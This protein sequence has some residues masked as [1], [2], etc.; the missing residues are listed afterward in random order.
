MYT[1]NQLAAFTLLETKDISDAIE[2]IIMYTKALENA[3]T[4]RLAKNYSDAML[5]DSSTS[6][7]TATEA[8]VIDAKEA[9]RRNIFDIVQKTEF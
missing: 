1:D 5:K 3:D 7:S 2:Y 9:L 8:K 4:V 6:H